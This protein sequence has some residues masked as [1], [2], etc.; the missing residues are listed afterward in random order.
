MKMSGNHVINR[1]LLNLGDD[2][3]KVLIEVNKQ[4]LK[5]AN[6]NLFERKSSDVWVLKFI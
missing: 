1:T 3:N 2:T 5:I 4:N 6:Q